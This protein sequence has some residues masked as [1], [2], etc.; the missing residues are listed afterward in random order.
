MSS[1]ILVQDVRG[2]VDYGIITIREDEFTA[3]FERLPDRLTVKGG[4]QLYEFASVPVDGGGTRGVAVVRCPS[5][6]ES[7]AQSVTGHMIRDL[8]PRMLLL[9]G[10]AGGVP[11]DDFSLGNVLL[12]SRLHD[13]SVTAALQGGGSQLNVSGGPVHR[14]VENLAAHLPA[15]LHRMPNWNTPESVQHIVPGVALPADLSAAE[16]YGPEEWKRKVIE[17]LRRHFPPG[18]N[19]R[20]PKAY[21]GATASS[22]QLVKDA[23]LVRQWQEAARSVTHIEMELAGVLQAARDADDGEVPVIAIR[24]LSDIVGFRRD[25]EW[26]GYACHS[27]ASF[28]LSLIKSRVI[29]DAT[30]WEWETPGLIHGKL[31][32]VNEW[33][34]GVASPP[35]VD[36]DKTSAVLAPLPARNAGSAC[37]RHFDSGT[38][39]GRQVDS[40]HFSFGQAGSLAYCFASRL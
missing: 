22:N 15:L 28:C 33:L 6:G 31:T 10:I 29:E 1:S 32:T 17:T 34:I 18:C 21:V 8:Q 25:P 24:G 13:F 3:M 2:R 19:R 12:A 36:G 7:I 11:S 40:G 16:L 38:R 35:Q 39:R 20:P 14:I 4:K 37:S 30:D 9:V 23:D 5:Q 27:A 26:T